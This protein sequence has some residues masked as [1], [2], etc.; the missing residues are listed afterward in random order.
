[1]TGFCT[2]VSGLYPLGKRYPKL[3]ALELFQRPVLSRR[4]MCELV[5]GT[6]SMDLTL[7]SGLPSQSEQ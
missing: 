7:S 6:V 2:V 4:G 5:G 3:I 1:M